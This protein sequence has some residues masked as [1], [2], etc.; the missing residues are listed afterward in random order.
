MFFPNYIDMSMKYKRDIHMKFDVPWLFLS[1]SMVYVLPLFISFFKYHNKE[2][3]QRKGKL[4]VQLGE[5]YSQCLTTSPYI[6]D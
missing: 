5:I 1:E 4:K 2:C 3:P 6:W